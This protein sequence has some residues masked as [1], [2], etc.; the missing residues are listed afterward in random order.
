MGDLSACALYACPLRVPFM[1]MGMGIRK[2]RQLAL[3]SL[4]ERLCA[5]RL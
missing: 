1:G 2:E 5:S 4:R 3:V